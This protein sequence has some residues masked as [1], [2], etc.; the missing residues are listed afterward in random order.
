MNST[1]ELTD[2]TMQ[3]DE[4]QSASSRSDTRNARC[5]NH[6]EAYLFHSCCGWV[7]VAGIV[8]QLRSAGEPLSLGCGSVWK[9]NKSRI[10]CFIRW[11]CA[12]VSLRSSLAARPRRWGSSS[13]VYGRIHRAGE[14]AVWRQPVMMLLLRQPSFRR[15]AG[16]GRWRGWGQP[17]THDETVKNALIGPETAVSP[18]N[19]GWWIIMRTERQ[20]AWESVR[21]SVR[22]CVRFIPQSDALWW[23]RRRR[24]TLKGK[25]I[26][27]NCGAWIRILSHSGQESQ[28]TKAPNPPQSS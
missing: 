28:A 1:G 14:N 2:A 13:P 9:V 6:Q 26:E 5:E 8:I 25:F 27:N 19:G 17:T 20:H 24:R 4:L 23:F 7:S 21:A 11:L 10:I 15:D 12:R 3:P 22:A 18:A 16:W